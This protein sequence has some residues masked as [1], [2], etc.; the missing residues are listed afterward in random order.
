MHLY[1]YTLYQVNCQQSVCTLQQI[2]TIL[3]GVNNMVK[4][5]LD[6]YLHE[7]KIT[8]YQLAKMT[9]IK[10]QTLDNYYKNRV[11][12]YDSFILSK[13]CEVLNCQISDILIYIREQNISLSVYNKIL[14]LYI[15]GDTM[16]QGE[17]HRVGGLLPCE[18]ASL[19]P[20]QY[21]LLRISLRSF[22]STKLTSPANL[23]S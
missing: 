6:K 21:F 20:M 15:M 10:Y 23:S 17:C 3:Y 16:T 13:I 1:K 22:R 9:Q 5:I 8:R 4:L 11:V 19:I 18:C 7:R 14:N 2:Y 12:R